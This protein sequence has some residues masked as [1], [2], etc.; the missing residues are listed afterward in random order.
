[1][2]RPGPGIDPDT[3]DP[4]DPGRWGHSLANLAEIMLPCLDAVGARSV[5]EVGA[6]AGDL[7]RLLVDWAATGGARVWAIDPAPEERLVALA[8]Q[9][10]SVELVCATSHEALRSVAVPDALVIDGDHNY[11]TVAEELRIIG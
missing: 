1:M 3:P 2:Q 4:S 6:Y 10:A 7:T 9:R 11:Y 5:V 8:E